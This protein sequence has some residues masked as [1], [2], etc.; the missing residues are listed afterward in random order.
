MDILQ[1]TRID[2]IRTLKSPKLYIVMLN[3]A[4]FLHNFIKNIKVYAAM[5]HIGITPYVYPVSF[6]NWINCIYILFSI[7][8]LMSISPL[9]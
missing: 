1:Q 3:S 6:S 2:I 4:F 5:E 7:T 9:L 8:I